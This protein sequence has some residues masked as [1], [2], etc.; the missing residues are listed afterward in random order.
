M[1]RQETEVLQ[2]R[3]SELLVKALNSQRELEASLGGNSDI[4]KQ[5]SMEA[6]DRIADAASLD[7]IF[8]ANAA[9][10]LPSTESVDGKPITILEINI[11][12]SQEQ[13]AK[14]GLGAYLYVKA[15][16]DLGEVH[17]FTTGSPNVVASLFQIQRLGLL[18]KARIVIKGRTTANGTLYQVLKP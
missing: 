14:G 12:K 4:A 3:G 17:E 16:D 13:F 15:H 9:S 1:A 10:T 2:P 6:V 5:L 7:D 11:Q 8:A 18:G